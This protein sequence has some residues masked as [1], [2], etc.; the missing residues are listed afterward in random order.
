MNMTSPMTERVLMVSRA[1]SIASIQLMQ[2]KTLNA[3]N[4]QNASAL[5]DT[6]RELAD[7]PSIRA[8]VL[9]GAGRA[10][11]AG[12]DLSYLESGSANQRAENAAALI[13]C[14]HNVVEAIISFPAPIL[15]V[16]HGAV[17]GGGLGLMLA[18]D[19]SIASNNTRFVFA[20]TGLGTSPDCGLTWF[21]TRMIG[22]RRALYWATLKQEF[23]ADE[24]LGLGLVQEVLEPEVLFERGMALAVQL[25]TLPRQG[26]LET[27]RLLCQSSDHTLTQQLQAE[28]TAFVSLAASDD[29]AEGI[30]A[31]QQHRPP[32]FA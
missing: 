2:P 4:L 22:V 11:I 25:S 30:K 27:R 24:A 8:V 20:Y 19:V 12:G 7:D 10:F 9:S 3:L 26:F 18:S 1:G 21:L 16:V 5:L 17:A 31:F 32:R 13:D 28:R 14:L 6:F 15:S 23:S 29:F